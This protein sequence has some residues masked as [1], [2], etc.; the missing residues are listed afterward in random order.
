MNISNDLLPL[1]E[2]GVR[3]GY[4][5]FSWESLKS[6]P[7]SE[8]E[9]Y[10]GQ[11]LKSDM[12]MRRQNL[13]KRNSRGNMFCMNKA[14]KGIYED[15]RNER[16]RYIAREKKIMNRLLGVPI[17]EESQNERETNESRKVYNLRYPLNYEGSNSADKKIEKEPFEK[18]RSKTEFRYISRNRSFSR[19]LSPIQ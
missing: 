16:E 3:G 13:S 2:S 15:L 11:S 19:S 17:K 6:M 10:L 18:E 8:R 14:R 1:K 4:E 12:F 9:H 5:N 7:R